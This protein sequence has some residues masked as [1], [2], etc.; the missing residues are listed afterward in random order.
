MGGC[1]VYHCDSSCRAED[2]WQGYKLF[3]YAFYSH[4][5]AHESEFRTSK[6]GGFLCIASRWNLPPF[7]GLL[8]LGCGF[9][10]SGIVFDTSSLS[11]FVQASSFGADLRRLAFPPTIPCAPPACS[12]FPSLKCT[13]S[14][15]CRKTAAILGSSCG[16]L[17]MRPSCSHTTWGGLCWKWFVTMMLDSVNCFP[18]RGCHMLRTLLTRLGPPW[19][20]L[21]PHSRACSHRCM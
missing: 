20:Q 6:L 8:L 14:G 5:E 19:L 1:L 13:A 21:T 16:D 10:E 12:S 17:T 18:D 7:T 15:N 4:S 11:V 9:P 3:F 2:Y